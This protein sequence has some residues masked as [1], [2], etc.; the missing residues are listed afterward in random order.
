MILHCKYHSV[1]LKTQPS[2]L[3][4]HVYQ[5][6]ILLNVEDHTNIRNYN[7]TVILGCV[8]YHKNDLYKTHLET[9]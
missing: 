2:V 3:Y 5:V 8:H 7:V 1:K 9:C 4:N 6:L